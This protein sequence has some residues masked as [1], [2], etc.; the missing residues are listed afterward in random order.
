M[1]HSPTGITWRMMILRCY[2]VGCHNYAVY[3][4][5]GIIVCEYLRASRHNLV[6]VIGIRPR[7]TTV[8]RIDNSG[9][10][11]CGTCAECC[12]KSWRL[13]VRWATPVQQSRNRKSNRIV[14]IGGTRKC[15]AEWAEIAGISQD[16]LL[17]RLCLG[18][19]HEQLLLPRGSSV[20]NRYAN[21]VYSTHPSTVKRRRYKNE[22]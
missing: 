7:G 20:N 15:V 22:S 10:Y 8:D 18:W 17:R 5:V 1:A 9:S 16:C 6:N 13:N 14:M 19:Q 2:D 4:A 3:G 21:H 12:E 11:T